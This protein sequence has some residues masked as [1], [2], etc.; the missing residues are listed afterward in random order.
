ML[1]AKGSSVVLMLFI[2]LVISSEHAL[3]R[4]TSQMEEPKI[5][6]VWSNTSPGY[7]SLG[8]KNRLAIRTSK[9]KGHN[10]PL[11][12]RFD[13]KPGIIRLMTIKYEFPDSKPVTVRK[14]ITDK[15]YQLISTGDKF[16]II[17][18]MHLREI[19]TIAC[20]DLITV[21]VDLIDYKLS[22]L[23]NGER[24]VT[25]HISMHNQIDKDKHFLVKAASANPGERLILWSLGE[26]RKFHDSRN[27]EFVYLVDPHDQRPN[28]ARTKSRLFAF[29]AVSTPIKTDNLEIKSLGPP[30]QVSEEANSPLLE[31]SDHTRL[32]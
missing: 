27:R 9:E 6:F 21:V 3:E 20:G 12:T 18:L 24:F 14:N 10:A 5:N 32:I 30:T 2:I 22:I 25:N 28:M 19:I 17:D 4:R 7:Y 23:V 13:V 11:I 1:V 15:D 26:L 16:F 31:V 29:K 8:D